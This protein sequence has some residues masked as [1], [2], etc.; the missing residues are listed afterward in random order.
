MPDVTPVQTLDDILEFI[1]VS[2]Y[3]Y[4]L[5]LMCGLSFMADAMEVSLLAFI[6]K[7][8]GSEWG[9]NNEEK[10][11]VVSVVFIGEMVGSIVWGPV[12]DHFGRKIAFLI[13]SLT[14]S[15]GGFAAAF[16]PNYTFLLLFLGI[17]GFGVGGLTVP[18]DLLAEFLPSSH[19][20][21]AL[22]YINYFWT[23]GSM[24][25]NGT[26]W[27]ILSKYGW[28]ALTLITA[29]P[30][31]LSTILSIIYL[32]ESPRWLLEEGMHMCYV[33]LILNCI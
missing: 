21:R 24:F 10:A 8:A 13:V 30:V 19:R 11:F 7:C 3:H 28:R 33:L 25:V 17:V 1:P 2:W 6:S 32:P 29:V 14:I 16:S 18:F 27:I 31:A 9:L 23:G 12:A 5:F 4:R 20:G 26:A 15:L 22:L